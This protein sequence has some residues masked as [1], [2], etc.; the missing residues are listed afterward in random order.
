MAHCNF[1]PAI[2]EIGAA[3]EVVHLGGGFQ[4]E[5]AFQMGE[6]F[7]QAAL[8][9]EDSAKAVVRCERISLNLQCS[10]QMSLGRFEISVISTDDAQHQTRGV[11]VSLL[12]Y[13]AL[14][15]AASQ[16]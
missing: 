1:G 9:H 15:I 3:H 10:A 14:E 5:R 2:L 7:P 11:V 4:S 16:D 8:A 12:H 13:C 6:R